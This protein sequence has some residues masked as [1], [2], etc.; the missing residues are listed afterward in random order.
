MGLAIRDPQARLAWG[1]LFHQ[2]IPISL[3]S[4]RE[5]GWGEGPEIVKG[6]GLGGWSFF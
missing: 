2:C 1:S 3:L 5:G 6:V 4:Y